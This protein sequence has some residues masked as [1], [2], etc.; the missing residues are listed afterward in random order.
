VLQF[1]FI[2]SQYG[3]IIIIQKYANN[4]Q[5]GHAPEIHLEGMALPDAPLSSLMDSTS[6][7]K[8]KTTKGEEIRARSLVRSTLGVEGRV[9]AQ[10]CGLGRLKSNSITHTNLHKPNHKLVNAQLESFWCM[11]EL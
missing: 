3:H 8:V 7:P 5:L 10:R 6:N 4:L 1:P 2:I 9:G 11:D